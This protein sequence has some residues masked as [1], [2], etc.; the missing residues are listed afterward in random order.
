MLWSWLNRESIDV[1]IS[2]IPI[3]PDMTSVFAKLDP[4]LAG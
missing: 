4:I 3:S 1:G 2:S